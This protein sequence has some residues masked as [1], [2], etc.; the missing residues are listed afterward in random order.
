MAIVLIVGMGPIVN[1]FIISLAEC[2]QLVAEVIGARWYQET[3]SGTVVASHC[4]DQR[5]CIHLR[6]NASDRQR[7]FRPVLSKYSDFGF[8]GRLRQRD[9]CRLNQIDSAS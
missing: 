1:V 5:N 3:M 2:H 7:W 6:D 9:V 8:N 4:S